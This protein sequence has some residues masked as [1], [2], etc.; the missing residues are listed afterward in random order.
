MA[1][2]LRLNRDRLRQAEEANNKINNLSDKRKSEI[3]DFR[4]S[5][6]Q[7]AMEDHPDLT[8][9]TALKMMEEFDIPLLIH[10]E[11][12]DKNVDIF[13]REKVFIDKYLINF[14][15]Y[16]PSLRII[17]EHIS[18]KEAAQFVLESGPTIAATIT[19][20]H[21]L[22]NRNDLFSGGIRPHHYC[23]P[24]LKR[25][26]HQTAIVDAALSGSPKF[27]LGTD[28]A[29]HPKNQKESSCGCAGIYSALSAIELYAEVFYK[30]NAIN[31]LENFSS[32]YG[33]SFYNLPINSSKIK[34]LQ[35]TSIV[36]KV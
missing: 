22:L 31:L 24:V 26:A 15:K 30:N 4:L 11:V 9:E 25:S 19:P 23:L 12:S 16:F 21:L 29:P 27:F 13:D 33:A 34:R 5:I 8:V 36:M 35:I 6:I 32:K 18:T 20:Q 17:F 3:G 2:K 10:G 1:T 28:S 14:H 7:S